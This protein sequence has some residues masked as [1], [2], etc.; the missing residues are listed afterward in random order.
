[1][2]SSITSDQR[3]L[4]STVLLPS[5]LQSLILILSVSILISRPVA[6]TAKN[7]PNTTVTNEITKASWQTTNEK[8]CNIYDNETLHAVMDRVC[9]LCHNMFSHQ[10]PNMRAQCRLVNSG[11][12]LFVYNNHNNLHIP[13]RRALISPCSH[14][15]IIQV[16]L[17]LLNPSKKSPAKSF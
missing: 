6:V 10:N 3:N 13:E 17:S 2:R 16:Y 1:M 12:V 14:I 8:Q 15:F 9:E 5:R 7:V 4:H 11:F